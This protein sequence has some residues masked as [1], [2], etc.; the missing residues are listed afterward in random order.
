MT[1]VEA[2]VPLRVVIPPQKGSVVLKP[3]HPTPLD[4]RIARQLLR[5][6]PGKLRIVEKPEQQETRPGET[7]FVAQPACGTIGVAWVDPAGCR[8]SGRVIKHGWDQDAGW[9]WLAVCHRDGS[10]TWIRED[11]IAAAWMITRERRERGLDSPT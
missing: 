8:Q 4:D 10:I 9:F 2:L 7:G 5:R 11:Q 6:L 1:L 3:G